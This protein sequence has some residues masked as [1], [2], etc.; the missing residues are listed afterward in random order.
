[1]QMSADVQHS[2]ADGFPKTVY[3]YPWQKIPLLVQSVVY[4]GQKLLLIVVV[5]IG[6]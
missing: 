4:Y 3:V 6:R 2:F 5:L 1:M